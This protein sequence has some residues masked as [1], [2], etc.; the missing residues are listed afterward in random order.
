MTG[1][2]GA[3]INPR[4]AEIFRGVLEASVVFKGLASEVTGYILQQGMILEAKKDDLVYFEHMP[5]GIGLY[6]VLEG[7]VGIFRSVS[8][9]AAEAQQIHLNTLTQGHCFGEYSLLDGRSTSAS[10]RALE[11]SR[12]FFLPRGEFLRLTDNDPATG[13][14]IYRNLLLYLIERLRQKD[15]E[16][17][18]G[19]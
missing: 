1:G 13:K 7:K 12:L 9:E 6:L 19:H 14:A 18:A 2:L 10:A 17:N 11:S 3:Y 5:G 15:K 16:P 4:E 8:P